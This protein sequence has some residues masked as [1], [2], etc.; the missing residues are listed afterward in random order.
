MYRVVTGRNAGLP[1][2]S[3]TP[4]SACFPPPANICWAAGGGR[5]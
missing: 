1:G 3:H 4:T 5:R 2:Q